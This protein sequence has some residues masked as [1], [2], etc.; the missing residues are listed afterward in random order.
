[1]TLTARMLWQ[2]IVRYGDYPRLKRRTLDILADTNPSL[3][4]VYMD[5]IRA[6]D[7]LGK[8]QERLCEMAELEE[9]QVGKT[10]VPTTPWPQHDPVP[11]LQCCS[12][13]YEDEWAEGETCP[14]RFA[15]DPH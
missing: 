8:A 2:R 15:T 9:V 13:C 1:M 7:A 14:V 3:L 5:M 12:F 10:R 4:H 11:P 6:S